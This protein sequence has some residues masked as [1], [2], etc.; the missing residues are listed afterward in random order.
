MDGKKQIQDR[1]MI[2]QRWAQILCCCSMAVSTSSRSQAQSVHVE[3][4]PMA[5]VQRKC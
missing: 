3:D 1:G 2:L 5:G 4:E